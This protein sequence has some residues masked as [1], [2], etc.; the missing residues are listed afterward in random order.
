MRNY[1]L[2]GAAAAAL[3]APMSAMAQ[4]TTSSIRGT[5]TQ[6][7]APVSDAEVLVT[8]VPS[9]TRSTAT[10]GSDGAFTVSGVRVGGPFTVVVNSDRGGTQI[11]DIFT[12]QGQTFDLPIDIG[13][14]TSADIV[15]TASSIL[16]AGVTSDGPQTVLTQR[17]ISKV[18]SVNR[19]IRDLARRDPFATLDLTNGGGSIS[20]AGVN[21]RFNN[22][23]I[24]GFSVKDRFGLNPDVNPT[25]RGPVPF[26]AI[27]QFSVSIAPYDVRQGG[28]T[29]GT[30]DTILLAGTNEFH[31]TGFYSQSTDGIQGKRI[32][33]FNATIPSY[34]SETYG[35]T[36]SGPIIKDKLFLMVS[37]ER[38]TDPRPLAINAIGQVPGATQALVDSV[39]AIAR[40]VYSYDTGGFLSITNNRDEKIVGRLDWNITD[41]QRFT[42][43]Y[44]NA[45]DQ[46]D[47]PQGSS[48]SLTTPAVGLASN[49]YRASNLIRSGIAQLNS[50]W[51]DKLSTEARFI[52][53]STTRGQEPLLGRGF[54]QFSVCTQPTSV[55]TTTPPN[56]VNNCGVGN[57]NVTFGP[58][59]SRQ[60]N[61][62]FFDTYG[63]SL[64]TRLSAGNHDFKLLFE[65]NENRTSNLFLQRSAGVYY[66]DSIADF[67]NRNASQFDYA[68]A[69]SGDIQDAAA[70]FKFGQYTFALQD[71]WR[72]S[73]TL[74]VSAGVRYDLYGQR[75]QVQLNP[76]FVT[77]YGF[78]NTQ[79]Y[80]GLDIFQPRFSF[81]FK[82]TRA[83]NIRGGA[84]IFG[85]GSPDIYLSN[86]FG[87]SGVQSNRI[88]TVTRATTTG[89]GAT[90][91]CTAPYTGANATVCT[92]ALNG[93][94]GT[95][96]PNSV[97]TFARTNL[98]ALANST[99]ASLAQD[100]TL[101]RVLKA[102]LSA[103]YDLFGF[104]FGADYVYTN[105]LSQVAFTD[106]RTQS[107]GTLPDGRRRY[108]AITAFSDTNSD[109]QLLSDARGRSHI[110]VV[111]FQKAFDWGLSFGGSYTLQDVTD[112]SPATSS[113][114]FSL[115]ASQP[116]ADP[117]FATLG[118]SADETKWAFKY[119]LGFDRAFFGDYRTVVQLFGETRAGRNYSFTMQSIGNRS[120]VFGTVGNNDRYLLYV[121]TSTSDPIV[122]YDSAATQTSLE[123]LINNTRLRDFRGQIAPKNIA[124]SRAFTRI[125]LH[126]EQEIPTFIGKSRISIFGDIE[127]LPNLINSDWGGLRQFGFPYTSANVQVQCLTTA[128]PTGTAPGAGV[129]NTAPTQ[130]C[131]QYR[132]SAFRDTNEQALSI[133]NSL[134]LIRVGARL[135]F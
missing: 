4:E 18:A 125:D 8:H 69:V 48:T 3:I 16:G 112:V 19:S 114:A 70:N 65:Y 2:L 77:R 5:V 43:S 97:N 57:P 28:F 32:G 55:V 127:N 90:A 11:A 123:T 91:T 13:A 130:A 53:A 9:G 79:T 47:I 94:T 23:T 15:V 111:R 45:F 56:A 33:S 73:D 60:S 104:Q 92:D 86:S 116:S 27:S 88:A 26:D 35:A 54:A 134:Y 93:V 118:T 135:S 63:G 129:V 71:D 10:T 22:F 68:T 7:G 82:P 14:D 37:A 42:L 122:S 109:I 102:T 87:G 95:S 76:F 81:D 101:P 62:L 12:V 106:L 78:D 51:T 17:D 131:T 25:G 61:T 64:L 119:N 41:G 89:T 132:Y 84:G 83:L 49:A 20:F 50:D 108:N 46:A 120:P 66:F 67:Q 100:F 85:G 128:T 99:T 98:G 126:L 31:G 24:N 115:Y 38:N 113:V 21:P 110:G 1:L 103:D 117:N 36:L 74:T 40:S 58:D 59:L 29:G 105:T 6:E 124:R 96:I 44:V 72:I 30:I 80:K 39:T 107:I 75:S 133:N 52:Y 34:K 121:P